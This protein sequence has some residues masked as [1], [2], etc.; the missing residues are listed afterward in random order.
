MS[1]LSLLLSLLVLLC[2]PSS[3]LA[4]KATPSPSPSPDE[5]DMSTEIVKIKHIDPAAAADVLQGLASRY[6]RI[7][8]NREL[9]VVT[10][11]DKTALVEKMLEVVADLDQPRA[12]LDFEI[13][14]IVAGPK[15]SDTGRPLNKDMDKVV[16]ELQKLFAYPHYSLKDSARI[17]M[18]A[19]KRAELQVAGQ[20]GYKIDLES[21]GQPGADTRLPLHI[22]VQRTWI[23]DGQTFHDTVVATSIEVSD[24]ETTVVGASRLNGD[25]TALVVI[26]KTTVEK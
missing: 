23:K 25:D 12:I 13:V 18:L 21:T 19:G 11:H 4:A 2:L 15:G 9:G 14:L 16:E 26:L 10:I 24:G 8:F 5:Q 22:K 6:G 17:R 1:R 3:A 7:E 20:E